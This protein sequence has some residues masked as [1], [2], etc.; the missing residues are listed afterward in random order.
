MSLWTNLPFLRITLVFAL[1]IIVARFNLAT[2]EVSCTLLACAFLVIAFIGV[3]F[4]KK[5]PKLLWGNL[6]LIS[7]FL[8]GNLSHEQYTLSNS[9]KTDLS[10]WTDSQVYIGI[11]SSFPSNK[12]N[13]I[14]YL[15]DIDLGLQDS[16][17]IQSPVRLL[18]YQRK[19]SI[20]T[21]GLN[22]GDKILVSGSP[23]QFEKAKNPYEFDFSQYMA[24]Q[25]VH[26]QHFVTS[27]QIRLLEKNQGNR[28]MSAV[29][30]IRSHFEEVIKSQING[31]NEQAIVLA[32]LLGIKDQLDTEIKASYAAA[33]AMHVLAVSGLHVSIIYFI[34]IWLFKGL[35]EGELKRYL[36]PSISIAA[37][38]LYAL[39]TGFSPSILRAV[40]MFSIIIFAQ[41]LN[42]KSQIFNSLAFAAFVLLLVDP[43]YLFNIGFQ[44]SFLA[45]AGIVYVYP[46][47]YAIWDIKSLLGDY[48]WKLTCVSIAA[49]LA[50][51][52]LSLYYFNQFP[53]FFLL[54]NIVVIPTAFGVM[55]LGISTLILSPI[56]N[57]IGWLLEKLVLFMS[58]FVQ[59]VEQLNG[60]VI[61]WIYISEFQTVMIYVIILAFFALLKFRNKSYVW[62]ICL[63]VMGFS[64]HRI[65]I[66]TKQF[67]ARELIFYSANQTPIIDQVQDFEANLFSIDSVSDFNSQIH[68]ITPY[69][70]HHSLPKPE[71]PILLSTHLDEFAKI[72]VFQ[73][74]KLLFFS[75]S[76][77]NDEI[78]FRLHADIVIISNESIHSL[79]ELDE[80]VD[81]KEVILDRS[82]RHFY[83][84]QLA[85]EAKI[86]G[87]NLYD[88]RDQAHQISL[89]RDEEL[90]NLLF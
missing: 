9:K 22:Y 16:T 73:G 43:F 82:N 18:L 45:V 88:L 40:S 85:R 51:F 80:I 54:A 20:L 44:L 69:R 41:V 50:T 19:D 84:N 66:L 76:F 31:K 90:L 23:S 61:D 14:V 70:I 57:S 32:L 46:K 49:Q 25:H 72:E 77:D 3:L 68:H 38:W 21:S 81:F 34:L 42:R 24:D 53:S 30:R 60:S 15:V 29:Y 12:K 87:I 75:S 83:S 59:Q 36:V 11:V 64:F 6:L 48:F 5:T 55:I 58:W 35:P 67:N 8:L 62:V 79:E 10:K 26:L 86:M 7:I 56:I 4:F 89:S 27:N 28:L 39:L 1:G 17:F 63:A 2:H 33:G 47:L 13:F 65:S 52:P 74:K 78:K 71:P 37:L